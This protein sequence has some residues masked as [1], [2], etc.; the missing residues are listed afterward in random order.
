M[1][2]RF[3]P[4][5]FILVFSTFLLTILLYIDRACIS[6][7]KE[8]I[9]RDLN[10]DMTDFGWVMAMFTL[11]YALFQTPAGKLADNRG[12]RDHYLVD[13]DPLVRPDSYDRCSLEL[14]IHDGHKIPLRRR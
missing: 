4:L 3:I 9:T 5:R 8:D 6:A 14:C 1:L 7:A 10:F 12:P 2:K 11:G 13:R